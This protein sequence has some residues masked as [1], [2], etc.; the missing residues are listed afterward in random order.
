MGLQLTVFYRPPGERMFLSNAKLRSALHNYTLGDHSADHKDADRT[1]E[2][3]ERLV[4]SETDRWLQSLVH[5]IKVMETEDNCS[6]QD[7]CPPVLQRLL[8]A[9]SMATP[10]AGFILNGASMGPVLRAVAQGNNVLSDPRS[11]S[12]IL[13][14]CPCLQLLL[15]SPLCPGGVAPALLRPTMVH[16]ADCLDKLTAGERQLF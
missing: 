2:D 4:D 14:S 11:V 7:S 5:L 8:A 9:L 13:D 15:S 12:L 10:P 16:L 1:L 6:Y 3:L